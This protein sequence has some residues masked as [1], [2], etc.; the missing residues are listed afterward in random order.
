MHHG[1][2]QKFSIVLTPTFVFQPP[3]TRSREPHLTSN[4]NTRA[5]ERRKVPSST[6]LAFQTA[7]KSIARSRS[8]RALQLP[9]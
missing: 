7:D 2:L 8:A 6:R 9:R 4:W 3:Q 1:R 5:E